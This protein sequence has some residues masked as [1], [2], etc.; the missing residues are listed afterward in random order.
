[1][2]LL[3]YLLPAAALAA[4]AL[5]QQPLRRTFASGELAEYHVR[6]RIEVE[7]HGTQPEKLGETTYAFAL[8]RRAEAAI[9]WN[10]RRRVVGPAGD[11]YASVEETLTDFSV[12]DVRIAPEDSPTRE[13]G[14][15]L[16]V[17]LD[18]WRSTAPLLL[19]Y[20]ETA[21]GQL[22]G[23]TP[24]GMMALG[25]D[26]P[27]VLTL[28]L[29]RA[30]RPAAALPDRPVHFGERWHEPRSATLAGWSQVRASETGEWLE[31]RDAAEPAVRLHIVQQI[32]AAVPADPNR[33][34]GPGEARFHGESLNTVSLVS[35]R[36]LAAT[37]SATREIT[38]ELPPVS[39][40]KE[41]PRFTARLAVQVQIEEV[42]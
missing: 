11:N 16:R 14:D 41:P 27:P 22:A 15:A 18:R 19:R 28:W 23:L 32:S 39:G 6:L 30:L 33:G 24:A 26:P 17:A 20:R 13:L 2:R 34:L 37:R 3:R 8:E 40:M 12:P 7:L 25:E 4:T 9:E 5:P 36:L 42:R 1:M 29:L 35:G 10:A 31:A 21:G 38:H